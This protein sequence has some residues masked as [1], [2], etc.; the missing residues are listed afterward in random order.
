MMPSDLFHHLTDTAC[1]PAGGS[2]RSLIAAA[3]PPV[4][5][6]KPSG[7]ERTSIEDWQP[8]ESTPVTTSQK[9]LARWSPGRLWTVRKGASRP[10][11]KCRPRFT[12]AVHLHPA[13]DRR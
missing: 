10:S 5:A 4:A 8:C 12:A 6:Y 1:E 3:L 9:L 13:V 7:S 2:L 11:G